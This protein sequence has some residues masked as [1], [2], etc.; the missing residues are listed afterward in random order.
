MN[1]T[2]MNLNE[3]DL[4]KLEG[5]S[6][7]GKNRIRENGIWWRIISLDGKDSSILS[8]KVCVVPNDKKREHNWRWIDLRD[9]RDMEMVE[10]L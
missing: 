8:T 6:R 1:E 4:V 9:D 7:H 10:V 2:T 5:I 3:G